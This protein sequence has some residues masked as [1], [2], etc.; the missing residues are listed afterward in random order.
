MDVVSKMQVMK[1]KESTFAARV[2][3]QTT[4]DFSA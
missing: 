4:G 3:V 2:A 1:W